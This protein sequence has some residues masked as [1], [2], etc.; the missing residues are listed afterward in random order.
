MVLC[1]DARYS[2]VRKPQRIIPVSA[3]SRSHRDVLKQEHS[4]TTALPM[5]QH[6]MKY[7]WT[8]LKLTEGRRI[9]TE[10]LY[11]GKP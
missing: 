10:E 1:S 6:S 5:M 4:C 2:I 11:Q 8:A 7:L 3:A 9:P